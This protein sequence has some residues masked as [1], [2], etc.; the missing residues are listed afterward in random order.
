M[1]KKEQKLIPYLKG[2]YKYSCYIKAIGYRRY[3]PWYFS[4]K[5]GRN[6]SVGELYEG[7]REA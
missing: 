6:R 2:Y 7:G 4:Y 3:L 1:V 5:I